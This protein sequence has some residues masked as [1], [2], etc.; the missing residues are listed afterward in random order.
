MSAPC[1]NYIMTY[2]E[3]GWP[4]SGCVNADG[5]DSVLDCKDCGNWLAG[6]QCPINDQEYYYRKNNGLSVGNYEP[7]MTEEECKQWFED[8]NKRYKGIE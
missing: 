5:V 7:D 3:D 4:N 1:Y 6:Y 8:Y 2:G